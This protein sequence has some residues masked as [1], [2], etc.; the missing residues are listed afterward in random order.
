[1]FHGSRIL[2]V[3]LRMHARGLARVEDGAWYVPIVKEKS[4]AEA[5]W[6][7]ADDE[8]WG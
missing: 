1:M 4:E 3:A 8:D 7:A 2:S 6:P 5:Y